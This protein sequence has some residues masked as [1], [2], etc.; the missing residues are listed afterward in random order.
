VPAQAWDGTLQLRE[1]LMLAISAVAIVLCLP[2]PNLGLLVASALLSYAVGESRLPR[3][4]KLALVLACMGLF[5]AGTHFFPRP[6]IRFVLWGQ[7]A[8][9]AF[10]ILRC[11]DYALSRRPE[12]GSLHFRDR[13]GR[14]FLWILF[15]PTVF[16]G[17]IVTYRDFYKS[18]HP[19]I[20]NWNQTVLRQVVK[21]AWGGVKYAGLAPA[22]QQLSVA[23]AAPASRVA[24]APLPLAVSLDPRLAVA[25]SLALDLIG[26]YLMFSGFTDMAIGLSRLLGFNLYENFDHPLLST[27]PL[28]FWQTS[29]ISTYRWL[30]THVFFPCWGHTQVTAKVL[31]TFLVSALWHCTIIP[32]DRWEGM[33]QVGAAFAIFGCAVVAITRLSRIGG[34]SRLGPTAPSPWV[35]GVVSAAKVAATFCFIALVHRLF[36]N[37]LT[38]RPLQD[39]VQ[40]YQRLFFGAN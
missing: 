19:E 22:L 26:F 10:F 7:R 28:R 14:F 20:A 35:G 27:S 1:S 16:A 29:N 11:V 12:T 36:W 15:L 32:L 13:L 18:Y 17:P 8:I 21:I 31:T 40:A 39:A 5:V 23:L 38:G 2:L 3:S 6:G 30:M 9:E 25:A 4:Q 33:L 34:E 37:G 24:A